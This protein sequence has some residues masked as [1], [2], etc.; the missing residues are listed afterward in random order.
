MKEWIQSVKTGEQKQVSRE[1]CPPMRVLCNGF[2]YL[3]DCPTWKRFEESNYKHN[4][5]RGWMMDHWEE[6][7]KLLEWKKVESPE[8]N[9]EKEDKVD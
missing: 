5:C 2:E 8:G 6:G 4:S 1:D 7:L 3:E 9:G